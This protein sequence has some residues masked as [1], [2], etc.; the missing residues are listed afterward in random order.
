MKKFIEEILNNQTFLDVLYNFESFYKGSDYE[1]NMSN[2]YNSSYKTVRFISK[3]TEWLFITD[4][5]DCYGIL[6][7]FVVKVDSEGQF[8]YV[9]HGFENL[10]EYLLKDKLNLSN[11]E[12]YCKQKNTT[13]EN[14]L[15][16]YKKLLKQ[17]S[18]NSNL[19][20]NEK[21]FDSFLHNNIG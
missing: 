1:Q 11:A 3:N 5:G 14:V 10:A 4:D 17:Y 16:D 21:E 7:R 2:F 18:I 8:I 6:D 13:L 19:I 9:C 20:I 12:Y 15:N